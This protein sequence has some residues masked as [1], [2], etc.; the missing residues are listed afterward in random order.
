MA[1]LHTWAGL[2][3][4]WVLYFMFL[5]GS[6]GYFDT[7]IDYWMRPE[8]PQRAGFPPAATSIA[9]ALQRIEEQAPNAQR[10]I[11]YPPNRRDVP[12]LSLYWST[13]PDSSGRVSSKNEVL[14]R[15]TG[16]PIAARATGGGEA[17]YQMHYVLR[18]LPSA[19]AY[20]IVGAATMFMLVA[21]LSGVITHK[22]IFS[23]FFTFRPRK[24]QRSWLDAHNA[25]GVMALPFH[26]MITYSGLVFFCFTYM[27]LV[28]AGSYGTGGANRQQFFDEVFARPGN[29]LPRANVAAP[30]ASLEA[31][32]GEAERRWGEGE[33][34]SID[35][36][37]PGDA[38][39][40]VSFTRAHVTPTSNGD[41]LDFDGGTGVLLPGSPIDRSGPTLV[42]DTMLS[43]HEGLFS[44]PALRW[45]YFLAGIAGT[46]MIGTGLVHWT[47]KRRKQSDRPHVG[48]RLVEHLNVGTIAGLP[49]AVAAYFL[50]NR[51]LPLGLA[52]RAAWEINA[53]F[54]AW[55]AM[56]AY[57]LLRPLR[58][59]WIE[60]CAV[61]AVLFAA[62][63]VVNALTTERHLGVSLPAGDWVFAGFDLTMLAFA[64]GFGA[65][66]YRL[67]KHPRATPA[68][69]SDRVD[70]SSTEPA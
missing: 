18:Y 24:G 2:L 13:L 41:H 1:W 17:L 36:R 31:M 16:A 50:A 14:D 52:G 9:F 34:R 43:L 15:T 70:L 67:R 69:A 38:N 5:T 66:A 54:L 30:F 46:A 32:A 57:P 27:P 51:L 56:L 33:I 21:I 44:G 42:N 26:L 48:S 53:L 64:A 63:P 47:A 23:D 8:I 7:E 10:F 3:L 35:V 39:A 55:A 59:A 65:A 68:D 12:E 28:V 61:A 45:L 49:I 6:A 40:R 58:R 60:Q 4:G 62:I 20:W 11:V 22:K 37:N 19:A 25:L 29:T